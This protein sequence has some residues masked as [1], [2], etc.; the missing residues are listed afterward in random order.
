[1]QNGIIH[2]KFW[3]R[4]AEGLPIALYRKDNNSPSRFRDKKPLLFVGGMHG[5]EPEGVRL[6]QDLLQWLILEASTESSSDYWPWILIP[7]LNVEGFQNKQRTNSRG[8]DLNR[9]FPTAD[10]T[11]SPQRDRYYTG[12]APASEPEVKSLVSLISAEQ[13]RVIFHFHSWNPCLIYTGDPG[14]NFAETLTVGNNYPVKAEIGYPTPGSLGE[15]GWHSMK[16]PV[17][18]IEEQEHSDLD[19]VWPHFS[20]GLKKILQGEVS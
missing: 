19:Q 8:V 18:C 6:A 11:Q 20:A 3:S 1:M 5:D 13:P 9:N 7:C 16:T 4:S 14:K 10:W 2:Q 12:P 17:I 15:W